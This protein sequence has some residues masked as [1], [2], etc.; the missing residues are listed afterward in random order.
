[1]TYTLMKPG[2]NRKTAHRVVFG[3][4]RYGGSG[5]R[6]LFVEQGINQLELIIRHL[7]A[8]SPQ[9]RLLRIA[10]E[11]W[12]LVV[13]VSYPLLA[14]TNTLIPHQGT[15]WL[16]ALRQFLSE[17]EA[18][19]H[20][21]ELHEKLPQPL[22]ESDVCIMGV[23]LD[24]PTISQ[25]H[26]Q[27]F[28]PCQLFYGVAYLSEITTADGSAV[29]RAAWEGTRE[30]MSPLLWPYQPQPGPKPFRAWRW[31]LATAFLKNHRPRVS[32]KIRDL[33]LQRQL[34]RWLPSLSA[35][36]LHWDSYFSPSNGNLFMVNSVD[37]QFTVHKPQ[38][39]RRHPKQPVRAFDIDPWPP[40]KPCQRRGPGRPSSRTQQ[41]RPPCHSAVACPSHPSDSPSDHLERL[42]LVSIQVGTIIALFGDVCRLA[43][44]LGSP[45]LRRSSL[46]GL[47][48]RRCQPARIL[49]RSSGNFGS[50]PDRMRQPSPRRRPKVLSSRRIWYP[51]YSAPH[52]PSQ[53]FYIT[54]NASLC[55][56][57]YCDSESLLKRIKASR[58]LS[59]KIPRR[60]LF[61]KVD[62]EMQI[63][64][65]LQAIGTKF[66]LEHVEGHQDTKYPDE[67]LSWAAQLNMLCD[68]EIATLHL[69]TATMPLPKVTFLPPSHMS[70]SI[71][72][73]TITH[74]ILTQ[75]R[76]F[77]RLPGLRAHLHQHH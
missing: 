14:T 2:F 7:R 55:F 70:L 58:R 35:F 33:T 36:Q 44:S 24:L 9:G 50:N 56:Q 18:F 39:T 28:E 71:G 32:R 26:L 31:L 53:I 21:G 1:M 61:S 27:A 52:L 40:P 68:A 63:L 57:L 20:I 11:W 38:K 23:I 54:G 5:F 17:M 15:H 77:A 64:S 75:L 4:S 59:R 41:I 46:P 72:Q 12:Q 60:F 3:P 66:I 22:R 10:I 16:T 43:R 6:D 30:R 37:A 13:V 51:G 47:R 62:G 74:H 49:W 76:T 8:G 25:A 34:R 45:S 48:R 19:L 73:H 69:E 29:S 65:T 42:Y 67:P